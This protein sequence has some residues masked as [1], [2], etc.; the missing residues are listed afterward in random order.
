MI[1]L[2][3]KETDEYGALLAIV[4]HPLLLIEATCDSRLRWSESREVGR[5]RELASRVNER[6]VSCTIPVNSALDMK[7]DQ[8]K[9]R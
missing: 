2:Y 7:T 6:R 8:Q 3:I 5:K 9:G 1:Y 4:P